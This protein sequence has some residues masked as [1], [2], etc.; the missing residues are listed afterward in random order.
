MKKYTV[1]AVLL[2]LFTTNF[3]PTV[4]CEI[5][6]DSVKAYGNGKTEYWAVRSTM[7]GN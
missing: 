2:L 4:S 5:S 3:I 7:V 6:E 1:L